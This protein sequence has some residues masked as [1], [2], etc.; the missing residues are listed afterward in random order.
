MPARALV[1]VADRSLEYPIAVLHAG[2]HPVHRLLAVLLA[3]MLRDR[4]EQV[5]DELGVGVLA[6]F[7]GRTHQNAARIAD[8]HTQI[9]V[10]HQ[11]ARKAADVVD[12]DR[13]RLFP[14]SFQVGQHRL[15]AGA[16][17]KTARRVITEDLNHLILLILGKLAAA[18]FL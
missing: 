2:A 13:V 7:D 4:G 5:L 6:K 12:D 16:R 1:P 3:L 18:S 9:E 11:T 14:L 10:R 15:H 17:R 8:L